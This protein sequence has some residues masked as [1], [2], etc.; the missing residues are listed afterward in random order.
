MEEFCTNQRRSEMRWQTNSHADLPPAGLA[1][2]LDRFLPP[3]PIRILVDHHGKALDLSPPSALLVPGDPHRLVNQPAFRGEI[4]PKMLAAARELANAA[5]RVPADAARQLP[6]HTRRAEL[7]RLADTT[8]NPRY[9]PPPSSLP[10]MP[11]ATN[12]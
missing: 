8:R 4:F 5:A 2:T 1:S 3:T 12:F 11:A 6:G 10:S 9:P 7:E